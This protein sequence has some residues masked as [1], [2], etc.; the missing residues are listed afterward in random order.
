LLVRP[1]PNEEEIDADDQTGTTRDDQKDGE[2]HDAAPEGSETKDPLPSVGREWGFVK[3][4]ADVM[5]Y[6]QD[7]NKKRAVIWPVFRS[8]VWLVS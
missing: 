2:F 5:E 1:G 6:G 3:R 8:V 7:A 4:P